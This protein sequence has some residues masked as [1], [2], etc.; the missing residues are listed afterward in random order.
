MGSPLITRTELRK[1]REEEEKH[2][3]KRTMQLQKDYEKEEKEIAKFYRREH[4]KNKPVTKTRTGEKNKM[5]ERN[6]FLNKAIFVVVVL[7]IIVFLA[8]V[9]L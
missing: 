6:H 1:R 5:R 2:V 9:F 3:E 8:V 7:L 4:K